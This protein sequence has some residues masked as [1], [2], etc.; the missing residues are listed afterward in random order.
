MTVEVTSGGLGLSCDTK[1]KGAR[2][3]EILVEWTTTAPIGKGICTFCMPNT[4]TA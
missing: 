1:G 4:E 2:I 3:E